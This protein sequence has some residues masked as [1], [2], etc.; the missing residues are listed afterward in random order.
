MRLTTDV[1]LTTTISHVG[2]MSLQSAR[3]DVVVAHKLAALVEDDRFRHFARE[4]LGDRSHVTDERQLIAGPDGHAEGGFVP[5]FAE[6]ER[7]RMARGARTAAAKPRC[8]SS[9]PSTRRLATS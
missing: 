8:A 9:F 3:R 7:S 2:R 4:L 1:P 6:L 5:V